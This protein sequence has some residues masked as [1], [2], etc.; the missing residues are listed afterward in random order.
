[1]AME[2]KW[3]DELLERITEIQEELAR[4]FI[5]IGVD[6]GY[7]GD[8]L[9]AQQ[10]LLFSPDTW[11]KLFKPRM[12]RLFLLFRDAGLP[13]ILHSD[14]DI[15]EIIPDLIDIGLSA[16]NPC[17]P[18][19][20]DHR[21]LKRE[22]GKDLAFYGGLSTQETLP[23]GTR[24]EVIDAGKRCI[25]DLAAD[26][27]GCIYGPSHRIMSDIPESNIEAYLETYQFLNME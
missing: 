4:R 7:F 9:G 21:W 15:R 18:E 20:L 6:G 24:D 3:T 10:G 12:K 5:D 22:Y 1:M 19:V 27:T 16:L 11:R 26:G 8:D 23:Y 13:V 2:P 17:Q 25:E 14:G